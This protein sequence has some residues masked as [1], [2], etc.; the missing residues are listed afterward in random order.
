MRTPIFSVTFLLPLLLVSCSHERPL[1]GNETLPPLD[2]TLLPGRTAF[3]D[4][5]AVVVLDEGTMEVFAQGEIPFSVFE[6]HRIVRILNPRGHPAGNIIVPYSSRSQVDAV[7]ART[8]RP[9]GTIIPLEEKSIYDVTL[10]P[11]FVFYSD[12]RAK[13]FTMPGIEDGAVVEIKYRMTLFDRTLWHAWSFQDAFPTVQS[14]FTLVGPSEWEIVWRAHGTDVQPAVNRAPRGFR[15]TYVWELKNIPAMLPEPSMPP[16]QELAV[17]IALAPLGFRTWSDVGSWLRGL[18]EPNLSTGRAAHDLVARLTEGSTTPRQK[19]QRLFEWVRDEVRYM[20]VEIGIGGFRPHPADEV[21]M[22]RYGDCK[23]MTILLCALAH[24]AGL[25]VVP[26][27]L[28]T[29]YNGRPDTTLPSPLQFDHVVAYAPEVDGG[30][31]M[32]ATEKGTPFG[33]IPW[34]DQG[35]PTVITGEGGQAIVR[36]SPRGPS[37]S[38]RTWTDWSVTLDR[39]GAAA[40]AGKSELWGASAGELRSTLQY[41]TP[42]RQRDWMELTLSAQCPNVRLDTLSIAGLSPCTDPLELQYTFR[43]PAF[44]D[45]KDSILILQPGRAMTGMISDNFHARVRRYPIRL[46]F[47]ERSTTRWRVRLP[48]GYRPSPDHRSDSLVSPFGTVRWHWDADD[49]DVAVEYDFLVTGE[50]VQPSSYREFQEFFDRTRLLALP[51]MTLEPTSPS[52][53]QP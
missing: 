16:R 22:N 2:L 36:I 11:N 15:S 53:G 44:A 21:L 37:D 17:R 39:S 27:Y 10:Y 26:A 34:Y 9:D 48:E 3:P 47:G 24:D 6:R 49:R 28:S 14:R 52:R 31:W 38:N 25:T 30:L 20:A 41:R 51:V 32:D 7:E 12:Q 35:L 29:W 13:I 1:T 18:N 5:G 4:A 23:D 33:Q 19:L 43:T 50:E 42:E 40:V 46:P 45:R 8:I